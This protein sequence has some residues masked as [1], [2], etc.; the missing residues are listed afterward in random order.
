MDLLKSVRTVNLE[1]CLFLVFKEALLARFPYCPNEGMVERTNTKMKLSK[2][3]SRG[4]RRI[5]GL[6][7]RLAIQIQ[8]WQK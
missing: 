4:I 1:I 7:I 3:I 5:Q 6:I 2:P 8:S